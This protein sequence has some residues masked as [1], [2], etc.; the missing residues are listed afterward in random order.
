MAEVFFALV[1]LDMAYDANTAHPGFG[2]PVSVCVLT[3][4]TIP[5]ARAVVAYFEKTVLRKL[6]FVRSSIQS[7]YRE[8]RQVSMITMNPINGAEDGTE[9]SFSTS[10]REIKS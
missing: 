7:D 10:R 6:S 9:D 8:Q 1:V 2:A 5:V 4:A 3:C